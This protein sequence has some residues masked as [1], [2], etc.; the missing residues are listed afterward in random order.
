MQLKVLLGIGLYLLAVQSWALE[1]A[2]CVYDP[3]G[4]QGEI[5]RRAQDIAQYAQSQQVKITLKSYK[6]E[7]DPLGSVENY[8]KLIKLAHNW[9][10]ALKLV[11]VLQLRIAIRLNS[12]NLQK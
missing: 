5:S 8:L 12:F 7:Q 11:S 9:I 4:P 3:V 10:M 6:N 2:W 1:T